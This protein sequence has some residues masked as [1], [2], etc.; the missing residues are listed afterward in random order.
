MNKEEFWQ[1]IESV[2]RTVPDGDHEMVVKRMCEE[3]S[4]HS[5]QDI[6]DWHLLTD[7]TDRLI[8]YSS[9]WYIL[10]CPDQGLREKIDETL[11]PIYRGEAEVRPVFKLSASEFD[12]IVDRSPFTFRQSELTM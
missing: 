12:E 5:P 1:T 7:L 3:L 4:H 2:N 6:L 10:S 9:G 11:I 8:V